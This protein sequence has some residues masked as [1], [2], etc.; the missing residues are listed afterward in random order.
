MRIQMMNTAG[1]NEAG[2]DG[3]G[4]FREFLTELLKT[5]FDPNR[6]FFRLT[7]DNQLYPNPGVEVIEPN[8]ALH[9]FFIGRVLGKVRRSFLENGVFFPLLGPL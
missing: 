1:L 3:G 8:F 2:I 9:Y 7:K 6:G 4:L 5:A